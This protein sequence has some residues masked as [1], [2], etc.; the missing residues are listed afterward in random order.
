MARKVLIKTNENNLIHFFYGINDYT[1]CGLDTNGDEHL[2]IQEPI[3]T[4]K[5]VNCFLC[6]NVVNFCR[7]IKDSE[8]SK[9]IK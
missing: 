7:E 4:N 6:L 3:N 2:G 5:P 1:L 9:T 8:L